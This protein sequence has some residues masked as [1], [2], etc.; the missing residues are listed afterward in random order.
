MYN[1]KINDFNFTEIKKK[2]KDYKDIKK[3]FFYES[4]WIDSC[5]DLKLSKK[6]SFY[7]EIFKKDK[8]I[9]IF[10]FE[11]KHF[12]FT[13]IL[14]WLFVDN[15]NF[16][17]PIIIDDESIDKKY[18]K[19]TLDDVYKIL[20]VD[21]IFLDK[22]PCLIQ[23]TDNP[24]KLNGMNKSEKIPIIN[25][26]NLSWLK[27]FKEISN[28]KTK[29][30]DRRKEKQLR[31]LGN[32][33][34]LITK[35]KIEKKRIFNF[36]IKNKILYLQ[37]KG[38]KSEIFEKLYSSLFDKIENNNKY[39]CS[40]IKI[41]N[42]IISSIVGRIENDKYYYLIPSYLDKDYKK[43]SP[44]RLLLKEQ[45]KWCFENKF[46]IFDFGPGE[47]NYKSHWSNDTSYYF[48]I[49]KAISFTGFILKGLYEIKKFLN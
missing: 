6:Q 4:E 45:I 43:F 17:S 31:D 33:E 2:I 26:K 40:A 25:M 38:I 13:K 8:L 47:F 7:V 11:I 32:L 18:L 1:F 21:L 37:K 48:K 49:I 16:V 44:G 22:N 3:S 10:F 14:N 36:T 19:K 34:I 39:V 9:M 42:R 5:L 15:Y 24:L 46:K 20:N 28:N 29:Q 41:N 30:T 23:K 27:Y 12:L 35:N